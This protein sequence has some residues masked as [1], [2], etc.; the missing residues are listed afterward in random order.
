[1]KRAPF[2]FLPLL[3]MFAVPAQAQAPDVEWLTV[4]SDHVTISNQA[5]Y[6]EAVRGLVDAFADA[7]ISDMSWVAVQSNTFGYAYV[8]QGTGPGDFP[9]LTENWYATMT[10]L[11]D[12]GMEMM[13]KSDEFVANREMSFIALRPDLSY[14]PDAVAITADLPYRHYTQLFVHPAKA[15]EF[16]ASIPDWIALYEE[17]GEEHGW[18]TYE[19]LTGKKLPK[20]LIVQAAE[21]AAAF[22]ARQAELEASMG[23]RIQELR[24][25]TG[26][27]LRSADESG[28]WVRPDLSYA[29]GN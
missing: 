25:K 15:K 28:G 4:F 24:A 23:D 9:A 13:T 7:E 1:M 8:F 5:A 27:T 6:E 11:G 29:G 16:E 21:S 26:P 19:I 17:A 22:H 18:R 3:L 14:L 12:R 20:Y 10:A 2:L